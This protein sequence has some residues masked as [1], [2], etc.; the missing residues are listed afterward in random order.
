MKAI[1]LSGTLLCAVVSGIQAKT[2]QFPEKDPVFSFTL[3]DD[4]TTKPSGNGGL[5][6]TAGDDSHYHFLLRPIP[7][8]TEKEV[9]TGLLELLP[10]LENPSLKDFKVG[11]VEEV[12]AGNMK[13]IVGKATATLGGSPVLLTARAFSPRK[14][15]Y[16][17]I[18]NMDFEKR[19][20]AHLDVMREILSSVKSVSAAAP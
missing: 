1:I 8:K 5:E 2:I 19:E 17:A 12:M 6:C 18:M 3:P 13:V 16:F 4:W 20:R 10:T 7:P 15:I 14:G 11:E 9:K